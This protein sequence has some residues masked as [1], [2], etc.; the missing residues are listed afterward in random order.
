[1]PRFSK[2]E[3]LC[4]KKAIASLFSEGEKKVV[5]PFRLMVNEMAHENTSGM[6]RVQILISVPKRSFKRA[7]DRNT[8]KRRIREAYRLHKEVL[9]TTISDRL[10][11]SDAYQVHIGFLYTA[12]KIEPWQLIQDKM[13]KALSELELPMW[14]LLPK[15]NQPN[16]KP[17]N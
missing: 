11:E 13:I 5:Y 9:Y 16:E 4:S 8:L 6:A 17:E 14:A 7:T 1:L 12:K 2:S 10:S 15:Q 3:R